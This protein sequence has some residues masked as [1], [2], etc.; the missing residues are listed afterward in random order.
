[1][2]NNHTITPEE[3]EA[4]IKG[5]QKSLGMAPACNKYRDNERMRNAITAFLEV[6]NKKGQQS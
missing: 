2:T 1:M 4:A 5:Y 3:L 6:R